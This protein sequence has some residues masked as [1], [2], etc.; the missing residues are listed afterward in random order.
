MSAPGTPARDAAGAACRN[1]AAAID[2]AYTRV[3]QAVMAL[4]GDERL[5]VLAALTVM[6]R[7]VKLLD[8][9]ADHYYG[10]EEQK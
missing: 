8:K 2:D 6:D 7:A 4:P 5:H 9:A 3:K 1:A 10:E